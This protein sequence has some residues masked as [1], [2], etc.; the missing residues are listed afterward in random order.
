MRP[1]KSV[2]WHEGSIE[3]LC[4]CQALALL[5]FCRQARLARELPLDADLR[6]IPRQAP[7]VFRSVVVRGLVEKIGAFAEHDEAMGKARRNPQLPVVLFAE[8]R[9]HP[10][11]E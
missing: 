9:T 4:R 6:I 3:H 5:V 8:F 7:F 2:D 11:P 1:A 10:F